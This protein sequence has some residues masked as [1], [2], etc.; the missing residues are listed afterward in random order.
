MALDFKITRGIPPE[1]FWEGFSA[2]WQNSQDRSPFKAPHILRYFVSRAGDKT[3]AFTCVKDG[4]LA[5]TLLLKEN[6]G[7]YTFLSDMKTD[8]NFIVLDRHL[9]LDEQKQFFE[10]L[11]QTVRRE[12]WVLILNNQPAWASYMPVF[13]EVGK[14]SGLFW[15]NFSYS[16]CPYVQAENPQTL[17]EQVNGSRELRYRMNKLKKQEAAEFEVL[18]DGFELERWVE[19]FCTAHVLRWADTP[20]PS[21]YRDPA[22]Q[23][24]LLE[25]L[26]AWNEDGLLVRFA[27]KVGPRR[28]GF[29]VGLLEENS[30]IHHSTTFHPDY[31]KFSPG[32]ALILFMTQWM[33]DH[34]LRMLDFGDG[35]EP[36]KYD[37][38]DQE[39][40]LNRIFISGKKDI[41]F[42]M[43]ASMIK[44]VRNHPKV[45][46]LYQNRFKP[47]ASRTAAALHIPD[48]LFGFLS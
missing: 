37:V 20:T 1:D 22:R 8:V 17:F 23:Q 41:T 24:F 19:E 28:V 18:T 46:H 4:R 21:A 39:H 44:F 35:N 7:V 33:K 26:K 2:L 27:V 11:L 25:C 29:V 32:K 3:T 40:V 36:Y 5:G 13:E 14:S 15:L 10:Q 34:G 30:L 16:V 45:Y 9:S 38:A 42:I 43:K 12:K 47:W 48:F 31:W 6:G